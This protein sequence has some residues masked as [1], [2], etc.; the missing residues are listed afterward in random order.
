MD[1][2]QGALPD[3]DEFDENAD[4]EYDDLDAFDDDNAAE[5]PNGND[6]ESTE[7][8][9]DADHGVLDT[10]EEDAISVPFDDDDQGAPYNEDQGAIVGHEHDDAGQR[11]APH[12]E[13]AEA[14]VRTYNLRDRNA[15][16]A[17]F[18]EAIDQPYSSK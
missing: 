11:E 6:D 8:P 5:A 7:A 17:N 2:V 13:V 12:G 10:D 4:N 3:Y 15:D 9:D 16:S 1:A 18:R 14:P